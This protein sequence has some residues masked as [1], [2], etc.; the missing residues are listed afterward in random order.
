M[1]RNQLLSSTVAAV[2]LLFPA[3]TNAQ[4]ASDRNVVLHFQIIHAD[5]Y[6]TIDPEIADIVEELRQL[7][8]FDGY[9]LVDAPRVTGI[10]SEGRTSVVS[11]RLSD[12]ELGTL[13]I[14]AYIE[15]SSDVN[16]AR[17]AVWVRHR[18][19]GI[20]DNVPGLEIIQVSVIV[21]DGQTVILGGRRQASSGA[22]I[23]VMS[24]DI[25]D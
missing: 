14:E 24:A 4:V 9:R 7:F 25:Q 16:S 12:E 22:L 17:V 6:E 20:P 10:V 1:R 2:L 8:R 3:A 5:G 18:E 19:P 21:R 13:E 15:A 11:V 23:L